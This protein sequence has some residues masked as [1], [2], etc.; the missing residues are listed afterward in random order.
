MLCPSSAFL[1]V[2]SFQILLVV[3]FISLYTYY[4]GGTFVLPRIILACFVLF[5]YLY[6]FL[7]LIRAVPVFSGKGIKCQIF[8]A[9]VVC[10]LTYIL[11][12][13]GSYCM[14]VVSWHTL[15]FG[16]AAVSVQNDCYMFRRYRFIYHFPVL[17][18]KLCR[19]CDCGTFPGISD[20]SVEGTF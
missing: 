19:V 13:F 16:P 7:Y 12:I 17:F 14:T 3:S 15:T 10:S 4:G 5:G 18:Q 8:N 6:L 20:P 11:N 1:S 2:H 9:E